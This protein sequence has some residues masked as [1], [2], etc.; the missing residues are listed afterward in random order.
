[1]RRSMLVVLGLLAGCASTPP[2]QMPMPEYFQY[3][4]MLHRAQVCEQRGA[5][6]PSL[7]AY[8]NTRIQ[9]DLAGYTYSPNLLQ[10]SL[11]G[12]ETSPVSAADCNQL[13]TRFAGWRDEYDR[14]SRES[15]GF[16]KH[17]T[18]YKGALGTNCYTF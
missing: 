18:C 7:L 14:N 8:G 2:P 1:M 12:M 9:Q 17:T 11:V 13:A 15:G 16:T 6:D 4:Q 10:R 5:I 3:A